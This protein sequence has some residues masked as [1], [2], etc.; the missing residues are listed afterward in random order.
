MLNMKESTTDQ[1][2]KVGRL[3]LKA[4][5]GVLVLSLLSL[6]FLTSMTF[7]KVF[8]LS[9]EVDLIPLKSILPGLGFYLLTDLSLI[10]FRNLLKKFLLKSRNTDQYLIKAPGV[11]LLAIVDFLFRPK[12]VSLTFE[13]LIAEWHSEYFEALNQKRKYKA[14]WITFRYRIHFARTFV[15]ALG[16]SKVFSLFEK[17]S[18]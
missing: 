4:V 15:M 10:Y 8:H 9:E 6:T 12:T 2:L 17:L 13:P 16:L 14:R 1:R 5:N 3:M 11:R 18:K 7:I